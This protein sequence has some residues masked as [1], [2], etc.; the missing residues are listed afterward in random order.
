VTDRLAEYYDAYW[1]PVVD[2]QAYEAHPVL[3]EV[4]KRAVGRDD[5]LL[6]FGCGNATTV[7][8][9]LQELSGTYVGVDVSEVAVESARKRG[10]DARRIEPGEE[11]PFP[12]GHFG[13]VVCFEVLEHLVEPRRAAQELFRVL[14]PG[15]FLVVSV[16]NVAYWVRRLEHAL[17]G[18]W[19]PYGDPLSVEQPWR[20][21]HLR[22]FTIRAL[23]R[24][25]S[26][27]GYSDMQIRGCNGAVLAE[28][29]L[30]HR[31][32]SGK[33]GSRPY[34]LLERLAP[35]LF[36]ATLIAAARRPTESVA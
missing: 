27:A 4:L 7:A 16:P 21:P 3:L 22:F 2:C 26:A 28:L 17:L 31:L 34:R 6:D 33:L 13:T 15:G 10:L 11:L 18:R 8:P 9:H 32:G 24:F 36:S 14:R 23:E 35:S 1:T 5:R 19:N 29:P 30:L 12:D 20:D 25:L